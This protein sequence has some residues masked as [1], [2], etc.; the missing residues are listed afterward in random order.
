MIKRNNE[1]DI[2]VK[3]NMRNGDG[4]ETIQKIWNEKTEL[5]ANT[6]LFAKLIVGK[7]SSIGFHKHENEEEVFV[8]LKGQAEMND[9]GKIEILN[10]GDSILTADGAGHSVRS[11]GEERLE[12]LAVISCY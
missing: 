6:R 8:I 2:I 9:N 11:I 3:K 1:F 5:K 4:E 7:G 12:M 10:P